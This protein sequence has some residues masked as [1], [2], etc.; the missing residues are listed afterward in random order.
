MTQS[1]KQNKSP[2]TDLKKIEIHKLCNKELKISK[3][4][5]ST[6]SENQCMNKEILQ[7]RNTKY[8]KQPSR[9]FGRM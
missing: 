2:K 1:K 4:R 9:N 6:N 3:K 7:K 5:F 8:K